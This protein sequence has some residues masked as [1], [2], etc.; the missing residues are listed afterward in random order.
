ML[1]ALRAKFTQHDRL[2]KQLLSTGTADL[3]EHTKNDKYWG[4]G[5]NGKGKNMLGKLLVILREELSKPESESE[6]EV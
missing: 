3:I 2:R 1:V 6:E 4:D 5:G